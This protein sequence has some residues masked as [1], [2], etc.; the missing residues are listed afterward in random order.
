M[1]YLIRKKYKKSKK[2]LLSRNFISEL[3][4]H[5]KKNPEEVCDFHRTSYSVTQIFYNE[6]TRY[7]V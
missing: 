6:I 7:V 2:I 4:F 1:E 5:S 3:R